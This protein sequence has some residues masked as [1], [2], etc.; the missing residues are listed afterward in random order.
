MVKPRIPLT[1]KRF[2]YRNAA[3][4]NLACTF[5]RERR[6]LKAA[7]EEKALEISTENLRFLPP[8]KGRNREDR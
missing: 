6:R 8:S 2:R 3:E 7:A 5:A 1:D 4:T